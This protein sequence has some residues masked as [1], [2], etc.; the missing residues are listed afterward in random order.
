[1]SFCFAVSWLFILNITNF[2]LL[3]TTVSS[4]DKDYH[5]KHWYGFE[6]SENNKPLS[7]NSQ[8]TY[9]LP[10]FKFFIT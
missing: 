9:S 4:M 6:N 2:K 1:M 10:N 8:L 7:F 3:L 5:L